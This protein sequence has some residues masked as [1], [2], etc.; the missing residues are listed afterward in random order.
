MKKKQT[1]LSVTVFKGSP[2][3]HQYKKIILFLMEL[4]ALGLH[5]LKYLLTII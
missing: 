3:P 5:V 1:P 2:P 4:R